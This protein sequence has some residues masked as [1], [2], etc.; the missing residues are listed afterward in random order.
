M[1]AQEI[2]FVLLKTLRTCVKGPHRFKEIVDHLSTM[3]FGSLPIIVI[4]TVFA[5]IVVSGEMACHMNLALSSYEMVPGVT[6]Q[7]IF[8]ELGIIIPS[9]LLV[10]KVGASTTA[11]VSTMKITDQIDALKLLKI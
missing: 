10:A 7:L 9:L 3:A 1:I 4:S 6:G 11:E 2:L 8:R 5:G